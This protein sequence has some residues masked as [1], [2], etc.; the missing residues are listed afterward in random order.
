VVCDLNPVAVTVEKSSLTE[1]PELRSSQVF[2]DG[3]GGGGGGE[4]GR[5]VLSHSEGGGVVALNPFA[6]D[7][8]SPEILVTRFL[9]E[10]GKEVDDE[11]RATDG[12][13]Q[14]G[15]PLLSER[16]ST[17]RE[18]MTV[19]YEKLPLIPRTPSATSPVPSVQTATSEFMSLFNNLSSCRQSERETMDLLDKETYNMI[20]KDR[21]TIGKG[22]GG[23]PRSTRGTRD[24]YDLHDV[25]GFCTSDWVLQV[26]S[27]SVRKDSYTSSLRS[28]TQ[29]D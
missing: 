15:L 13:V 8:N 12:E 22:G 19:M 3:G 23:V 21:P 11:T 29:V 26:H 5:G 6:K 2:T 17:T 24:L 4:G 27:S 28:H 9:K 7:T 25:R 16:V 10:E 18:R 1:D 20:F 14:S